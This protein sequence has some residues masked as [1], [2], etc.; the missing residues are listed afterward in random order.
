MIGLTPKLISVFASVLDEP[1]EQLDAETRNKVIAVV[2]FIHGKNASL[3]QGSE[4]LM[5]CI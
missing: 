4:V 2:K 1:A 5:K 3:I